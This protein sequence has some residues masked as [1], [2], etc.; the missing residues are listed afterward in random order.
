MKKVY[1]GIG[2][3]AVLEG[4]MMKNKNKYS[5]ACRLNDGS[6]KSIENDCISISEKYKINKIPF[7][8][9]V[10]MFIESM[11]L[12]YKTLTLSASFME[13]DIEEKPS[14][15]EVFIEKKL[16]KKFFNIL[17]G[18]T[19]IFSILI[20]IIIFMLLPAFISSLFLFFTN[21]SFFIAFIEG[22]IR[23]ILFISYIKAISKMKEIKRTFE[24]HGAEHKCINC[25]ENG[26]DLNVENVLKSSKEHKR[27]GTSFVV[28]VMIISIFFF[29]FIPTNT[30]L[31]KF[32]SR[33]LFIPLIA[34][35]SYE[36]LRFAGKF[37]NK[38]VDFISKPGMWMQGLTTYEPDKYEVE[39]AI[40]AV[41]KVFDWKKFKED[42]FYDL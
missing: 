39:V 31:V 1:S 36:I 26:L 40:C 42:N 12:G 21:N 16:N 8:R 25:I 4:I 37:N 30:L 10:F 11:I 2:G 20:A 13:D 24:Y 33:L 6:I 41:E 17:M 28:I 7:L 23:I 9:G 35:I 27:C 19:T 3:Q 29:M 15:F 34:G 18:I 5:I 14:K 32:V 38:F 22:I